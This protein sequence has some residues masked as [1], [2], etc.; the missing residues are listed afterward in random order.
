[1][2]K[3]RFQLY[4][5]SVSDRMT[6]Q[7]TMLQAILARSGRKRMRADRRSPA[8]ADVPTVREGYALGG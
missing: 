1:M 8:R 7:G 5:H 6:A 4:M 3:R 2:S